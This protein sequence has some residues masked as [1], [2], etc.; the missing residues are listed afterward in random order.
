MIRKYIWWS[1]YDYQGSAHLGELFW[2]F[3][4]AHDGLEQQFE[5]LVLQQLLFLQVD[6]CMTET[7]SRKKEVHF[8]SKYKLILIW[9]LVSN[10]LRDS[11]VL[12]H[13]QTLLLH[14][15]H[16]YVQEEE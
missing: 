15:L 5:I 7:D 13:C 14:Y 12:L 3:G 16:L 10:V 11:W 1:G 6:E 8:V 4:V 9:M 2:M